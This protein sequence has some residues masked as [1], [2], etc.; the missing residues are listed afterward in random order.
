MI[1]TIEFSCN[2]K[3]EKLCVLS[4]DKIVVG[5][6]DF[7]KAY[8]DIVRDLDGCNP[9]YKIFLNGRL[10]AWA[11]IVNFIYPEMKIECRPEKDGITGL[12][13]EYTIW[14]NERCEL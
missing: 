12:D 14:K 3:K 1:R 10:A 6:W 5:C 7:D 4:Y 2:S 8:F 11:D 9:K 13:L